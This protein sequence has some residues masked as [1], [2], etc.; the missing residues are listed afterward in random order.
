MTEAATAER[1]DLAEK[2]S[3]FLLGV[4]ERMGI[5]ADIDIK[6]DKDAH[7]ARDPDQGYRAGDR[8]SRRRDGRAPAPG[9][10][11]RLPRARAASGPS[12]SSSTPVASATSR[13]SA[14]GRWASGW[15][16]KALETKQIVELQPM[17]RAR[18]PHRPHGDLGDRRA[19]DAQ[20]G[21][22]RGPPHPHRPR[23]GA[24]EPSTTRSRPS[25]R[26]RAPAASGSCG[27]AD[28]R[29][30]SIAAAALG[31]AA[32]ALDRARARRLARGRRRGAA[33]PGARV[34]DAR[35]RRRSPARTSPSCTATAGPQNL[36]KLLAS[37]VERGARIAEPGEFTRRAVEHGKLDLLRAEALLD[38]IHAGSERAWR[39]AQANLGGQARAGARGDRAERAVACS[40]SSRAGSTSP[41]RISSRRATPGSTARSRRSARGVR[42][43]GGRVPPRPRCHARDHASRWSGPVNVGKSSLLNA[44]VGSERALVAPQPGTTRDWL[45]VDDGVGRRRGD[46]VDT[47]GH[48]RD[49][50]R[51]SSGAASRS[52]RRASRR[53]TSCWSS[54]T[55]RRRGTT[56]RGTR[57][58]R[59]WSGARRRPRRRGARRGRDLGDDRAQ[60][61]EDAQAARARGRRR[62]RSRRGRAA[63]S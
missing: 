52:A 15:R 44:L 22:G 23:P 9:Q 62:R 28:P 63:R 12:R 58:A 26:R 18:P 61:L 30:I 20:R 51:R 11:G 53:R 31:I 54:T 59:S 7:H 16:E 43:A 29:A 40:P 27:S 50:R 56:A 37:V 39:L 49:D 19:D 48:A 6:D 13:S 33:R 36:G 5:S 8:S 32:D 21:R 45:E 38:V 1:E 41:R 35:A 57:I 14:C 34:R 17:T 55:A 10:Q 42:G 3:E 4:L 2:A 47:A 60:G 24:S 25:R 46:A